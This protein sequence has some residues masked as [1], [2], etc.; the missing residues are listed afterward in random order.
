MPSKNI[1]SL[2][3]PALLTTIVLLSLATATQ[4]QKTGES[5]LNVKDTIP[6]SVE[7]ADVRALIEKSRYSNLVDSLNKRK[8][9]P[10]GIVP[11]RSRFDTLFTNKIKG[12][13]FSG[14]NDPAVGEFLYYV[15]NNF[16]AD[17]V[18]KVMKNFSMAGDSASMQ[19]YIGT[20]LRGFYSVS[21]LESFKIPSFDKLVNN[22]FNG[23]EYNIARDNTALAPSPWMHQLSVNDQVQIMDIPFQVGFSNLSNEYVPLQYNNLMK[24]SFDKDGFKQGLQQKLGKYYNMKKYLLA[25]MDVLSYVKNHFETELLQQVKGVSNEV[26]TDP[27]AFLKSKLSNEELLKLD[28]DQIRE[29]LL[30]NSEVLSIHDRLQ[31]SQQLLT[32][33]GASM[34]A[35][36]KDSL[37]QSMKSQSA[38]LASVEQLSNRVSALKNKMDASGINA[39]QVTRLQQKLNANAE[40]SLQQPQVIKEAANNLLPLNGLQRFFSSVSGLNAG[41]FG[42]NGSERGINTLLRGGLDLSVLKKKNTFSG[43]LGSVKDGGFLKDNGLQNSIFSSASFMQFL[44]LGKGEE[45]KNNTRVTV[46]N[47]NTTS[48]N[49]ANF[50]QLALPRNILAGTISKTFRVRRAGVVEAEISKSATQYKNTVS[51]NADQVMEA[52]SALFSYTDDLFQTLSA[53]LRYSDEWEKAG[54]SH[55]V[56]VSYAGFGY[57]NP[58]NPSAAKGSWQYDMQLRKQ[59]TRNG[60]VQ[61][62]FA[63]RTYNYSG[64]GDKQWNNMQFDL[65]GRYRFSRKLTLGAKLNQ[66]QLVRREA[67]T[68]Q[69]MYVSR[70]VSADAQYAGRIK[71]ISQRSMLSL[72]WQQFDNIAVQQGGQ[73]NLLLIQWVTTVPVG[74][75]VISVNTFYNKEIADH[76]LMGDLLTAEAGL[77]FPVLKTIMLNSSLTYLNNSIAARQIGLR[78]SVSTTVLKNCTVGLFVDC[79]KNLVTPVNPWLYGNFRGELS[80]HYQFK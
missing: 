15:R 31:G 47:S 56:H 22:N 38:Y 54:L 17:R 16:G 19:K 18:N 72:G 52:K 42:K 49:M 63:N 65:Q 62:R 40:E 58:G 53:G 41:T 50:S 68:K 1:L 4:G 61:G 39:N 51:P 24:V 10:Q 64:D 48:P 32:E 80:V 23:V 30:S 8:M 69:K 73:S 25:D 33:Y 74:S 21:G 78:Q 9:F 37:L 59:I 27:N 5:K 12:S 44:Q 43:G 46:I 28:N 76:E 67:D 3:K 35:A 34:T 79:R 13:A 2:R 75:K 14:M 6:G 66:Y 55:D 57:S 60:H 11:G 26:I 7:A 20:K 36:Q 77:G 71:G 29:K 70:K 45:G